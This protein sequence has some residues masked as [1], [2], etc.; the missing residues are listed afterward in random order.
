MQNFLWTEA[1]IKTMV[2]NALSGG[3]IEGTKNTLAGWNE[4][5]C[6]L[7]DETPPSVEHTNTNT[8]P[9]RSYDITCQD[10]KSGLAEINVTGSS[11]FKVDIPPFTAGTNDPIIVTATNI[12]QSE[13]SSVDL[14]V[15]DVAGNVTYYDPED[16]PS[17]EEQKSSGG[18]GGGGCFIAT[19]ADG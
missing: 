5:F 14:E 11:N 17:S 19:A 3:D 18:G 2:C 6:P 12:N 9:L 16:N 8:G 13:N 1:Q 10:K 7:D 4:E 15:I